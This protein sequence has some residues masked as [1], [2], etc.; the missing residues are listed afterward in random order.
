[1]YC[2]STTGCGTGVRVVVVYVSDAR[3]QYRSL[4][5]DRENMLNLRAE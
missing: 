3:L 1:M 2:C 4:Q 5:R